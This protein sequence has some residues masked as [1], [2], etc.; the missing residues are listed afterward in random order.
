MECCVSSDNGG[1]QDKV[2]GLLEV[3]AKPIIV[4]IV[5]IVV[6]IIIIIGSVVAWIA[7][8]SANTSVSD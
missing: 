7:T 4:I 3:F 8:S 1:S 2:G 6:I 5:I